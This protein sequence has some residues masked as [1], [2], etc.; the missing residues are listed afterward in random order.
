[1]KKLL[2]GLILLLPA[3]S[4]TDMP[5]ANFL[6]CFELEAAAL[7]QFFSSTTSVGGLI[8]PVDAEGQP[9][10]S[11]DQMIAAFERCG[12]DPDQAPLLEAIRQLNSFPAEE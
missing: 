5:Q 11:T 6:G 8:V 7:I 12:I 1:M 10:L 2:I 9:L 3:C 4:S